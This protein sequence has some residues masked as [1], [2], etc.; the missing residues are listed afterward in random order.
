MRA[1]A[2]AF[3]AFALVCSVFVHE[4]EKFSRK[5]TQ[6]ESR[7][8]SDDALQTFYIPPTC[9]PS[10][11]G[12]LDWTVLF[13]HAR[14]THRV[15]EAH[16]AIVDRSCDISHADE[17]KQF[18][19][20]RQLIVVERG[21]SQVWKE[22]KKYAAFGPENIRFAATNCRQPYFRKGHDICI[23]L[24][25]KATCATQSF[26][27]KKKYHATFKGTGYFKGYGQHRFLLELF[28]NPDRGIIVAVTTRHVT[29]DQQILLTSDLT[30][31]KFN[32]KEQ[33]AKTF[34]YCD[35]LNTTFAFVPGGRSPA[36][37]RLLE[38]LHSG[39]LPLLFLDRG[40][41]N[42]VLP[43]SNIIDWNGCM[44]PKLYISELED[45]LTNLT[46]ISK[47]KHAC[48]KIFE[49]SFVSDS[50]QVETFLRSIRALLSE[51]RV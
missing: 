28:H 14:R 22:E 32:E 7:E 26:V 1:R 44:E 27:A 36:S 46:T 13:R 30:R 17:L 38:A 41:G 23:T 25:A 8:L 45:A 42:V 2:R 48:S 19:E 50:K 20:K 40:D 39:A 11:T 49:E 21:P 51:G 5:V 29:N 16:F 9:T 12:S 43:Y 15:C 35:L 4:Q 34:E 31:I 6:R 47:R 10:D 24:R 37:F 33:Y 18:A 3:L